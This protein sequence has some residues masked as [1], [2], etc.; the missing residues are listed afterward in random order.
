M[1]VE[2]VM[3][4]LGMVM[5]EGTV[6]QWT[7]SSGDE[8]QQGEVIAEI[9]TEKISYELEAT[10]SG[11]LHTV[12]TDGDVVPVS[13]VLGYLLAQGEEAPEPPPRP[14]PVSRAT[15]TAPR[16]AAAAPARAAG[17]Q[18]PST[19]GARKLATSMG[20]DLAQVTPTGPRGRVVEAD[21]RAHAE[22]EAQPA[23]P[24]VLQGMPEPS[25]VVPMTGMRKAIADHMRTSIATTAQLTFSLEV[26]VTE[27]MR[28]RKEIS[29]SDGR[30]ITST[31]VLVKAC[32][33]TIKRFPIHNT[34]LADGK[35]LYFDDINI[36][37]AVA[38]RDGLI[39]PVVKDLEDKSL[40]DIADET[41]QLVASAQEGKLTPDDVQGGTFTIS[42]LGTV[43]AFTPILNRGQ[44]AILGVGRSVQKPA[45]VDG[46]ITIRERMTLSL[47]TDHQVIDGAVAAG[48]LRRLQQII[49]R[50]ARLFK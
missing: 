40:F 31:H 8:V 11:V 35:V 23:G 47:T 28:L 24:A 42:V 16:R 50:P 10:E 45:V 1:A 44:S 18:V 49:E 15:P 5:T 32:A 36:G 30:T 21:V 34:V 2:I 3:P 14:T 26:D 19:P 33:E 46:E 20:V 37:L 39:V 13:G 27:M 38:L 22:K 41:D 6:A 43:D 29:E 25:K 4:K 7:R 48:F 9:E 12:V 17:D